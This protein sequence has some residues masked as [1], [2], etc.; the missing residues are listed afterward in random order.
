M[1]SSTKATFLNRVF[2][3]AA[4]PSRAFSVAFNVKSKFETAYELKMKN[5]ATQPKKAYAHSFHNL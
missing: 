2:S 1:L 4:P 5:L 3:S